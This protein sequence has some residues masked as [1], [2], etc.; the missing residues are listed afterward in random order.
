MKY[1]QN[2]LRGR[3][4]KLTVLVDNN[5]FIDEYYLGEPAVSY[6]IEDN[7]VKLLFDAGYSDIFISN[8][9]LLNIDL[10]KLTHIVLSHGHD[11]HT[12]GLLYLK[13]QYDLS[14]V[15]LI[16]HPDCFYPKQ[17]D[18]LDIGSP[19]TLEEMKAITKVKLSKEPFEINERLV[20]L[21]EIPKLVDFETR[22][23]IGEVIKE[24]GAE[25]DTLLDDTAIVYKEEEGL[26]IITG[27]SHSGICNIIEHAK[28]VCKSDKILGVIGGFHIFDCDER[29]NSTIDYLKKQEIPMLYPGHCISFQAKSQINNFLEIKDVGVGL[30]IKIVD[31]A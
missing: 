30:E 4:M 6:Y 8:A 23:P 27:C 1:N 22:I 7:K 10:N 19:L 9:K 18:G 15:E 31:K 26:F 28:K 3:E 29:L 13:N 24:G 25:I 21:G 14:N 11:D 5:T 12:K 16:A 2:L 17:I 20:F